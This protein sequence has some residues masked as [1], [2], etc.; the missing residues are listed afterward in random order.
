MKLKKEM[1]E[2]CPLID[3]CEHLI[4]EHTFQ[5]LCNSPA[6]I[7]CPDAREVAKKYM[8][9]PREWQKLEKEVSK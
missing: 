8:K 4:L 2:R 5:Y 9:K 6:W 3:S 7:Y 1:D